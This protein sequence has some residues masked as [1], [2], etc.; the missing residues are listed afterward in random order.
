LLTLAALLAVLAIAAPAAAT[1]IAKRT[2][3]LDGGGRA[4]S[5]RPVVSDDGSSVVFDSENPNLADDP[6]GRRR[7]IFV[8]DIDSNDTRLITE[9]TGT[10]GANGFS[11][12]GAISSDGFVVGFESEASNLVAT[13]PNGR[14]DVFIRPGVAP[15]AIVSRG[16]GGEPADGDSGEVDLSSSGR[17]M[18]FTSKASNLVEDDD[19]EVRDVFYVDLY[20]G[21]IHR[22][23]QQRDGTS[24]NGASRAPA[25]SPDG[26][27]V[28]FY[29]DADNLT[30]GDNR[31]LPDV[32]LADVK[33]GRIRRVS[34]SSSERSQNDAVEPPFVQVS[35]VSDRGRYVVFDSDATNL[36][37]R[38]R[39]GHTDVFL[40][41]VRRGRTF[42]ISHAPRFEANSDSVYPRI[43]PNGRFVT[44]ESFANNLFPLDGDGA[45]SFLF[46]RRLDLATMLDVQ[47]SGKVKPLK[48]AQQLLQRPSVS[49]DGNVTSFTSNARLVPGDRDRLEDAYVRR[50]DPAVVRIRLRHLRYRLRAD[51]P[52]AG[53]FFCRLRVFVGFCPARGNLA[54]LR[55]G[56]YRFR[57]RAVG[58]G[59]RPGPLAHSRFRR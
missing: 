2:S 14:R 33:S 40:R 25:I 50:T 17:Y 48:G 8:R 52:H 39:R 30:A 32:F 4:D 55:P 49:A 23:S 37:A 12:R 38:D 21:I 51:D 24:G 45:D 56:R 46:D 20:N 22:V 10:R 53:I 54:R 59:M 35:D 31:D 36:V 42:R 13:D 9:A 6:N 19:N 11:L 3:A 58:P 18:V 1:R 57:A 16:L 7:D 29:S 28:S 47:N 34:V 43:T 27:Y 26:R 5:K 15:V 41:D 44:F